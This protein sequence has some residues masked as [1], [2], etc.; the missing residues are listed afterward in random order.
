MPSAAGP[1]TVTSL[2]AVPYWDKS[3]GVLSVG[4]R[5]VK[6]FRVPA[7]NQAA[8]LSAFEEEGW[9]RRIDNPLPPEAHVDPKYRLRFTTGRLNHAQQSSGIRFFGDGTGEGVCWELSS[10]A[11][12]S[13]GPRTA[14]PPN[15]RAA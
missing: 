12:A 8:V 11:A 6:R 2:D 3:S 9:P 15:C 1:A 14:A 5:I 10:Q 7:P 13:L 4:G